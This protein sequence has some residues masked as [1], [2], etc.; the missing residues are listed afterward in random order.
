MRDREVNGKQ[1]EVVVPLYSRLMAKGAGPQNIQGIFGTTNWNW[2]LDDEGS[3]VFVKA[4][5]EEHEF[6]P[7]Q[8]AHTAYVQTLLYANAVETAGTFYPPEVI[9]ALEGSEFSGIGPGKGLYRACDHQAFHD[10][11]V[12]RGKAPDQMDNEYDLLELV[13]RV[14]RDQIGYEC[15]LMGGE[16]GPYV[17]EA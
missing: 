8:A 6:P 17:P 9:K 14:P 12:V 1:M 15:D 3:Q 4:F 2:H 7:S 13:E 10:I 5:E 16:L 11:L